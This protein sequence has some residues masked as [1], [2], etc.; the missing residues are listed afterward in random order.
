VYEQ[1]C[2]GSCDVTFSPGTFQLAL[3]LNDGAT[4]PIDAPL[5]LDGA[6]DMKATYVDRSGRRIAGLLVLLGGVTGGLT[7]GI[8]SLVPDCDSSGRNCKTNTTGLLLGGALLG[9]GLGI[10]I[11]LMG[12]KDDVRINLVPRKQAASAGATLELAKRF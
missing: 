6:S 4:V 2:E 10:G 12:T 3:S 11:P 1:V 8:I 9:A 7:Y 5:K